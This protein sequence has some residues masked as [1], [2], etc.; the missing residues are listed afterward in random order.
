M[1]M[2]DRATSQ[3]AK[4]IHGVVSALVTNHLAG[5]HCIGGHLCFK[6]TK[7]TNYRTKTVSFVALLTLEHKPDNSAHSPNKLTM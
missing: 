5:F 7:E 6:A 4:D 2:A 3:C 1:D